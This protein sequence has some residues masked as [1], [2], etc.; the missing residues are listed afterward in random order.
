VQNNVP[1]SVLDY[2]A[3]VHEFYFKTSFLQNLGYF[4]HVLFSMKFH[5]YFSYM[6]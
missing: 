1:Y 2:M 4:P 6:V 3:L 5:C